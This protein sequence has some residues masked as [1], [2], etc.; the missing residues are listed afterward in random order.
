MNSDGALNQPHQLKGGHRLHWPRMRR[1][2]I[3]EKKKKKKEK[4]KENVE[5]HQVSTI[6]RLGNPHDHP[7]ANSEPLRSPNPLSYAE[8]CHGAAINVRH[9]LSVCLRF[10]DLGLAAVSPSTFII[11]ASI[12]RIRVTAK[13]AVYIY[14]YI[15]IWARHPYIYTHTRTHYIHT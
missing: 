1:N 4:K 14:I 12:Q 2:D 11:G 9:V 10:V 6:G 5:N 13:V 7:T 15:Y 8:T 3:P